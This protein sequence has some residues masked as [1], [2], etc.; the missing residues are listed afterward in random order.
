[1]IE[2]TETMTTRDGVELVATL[3]RPEGDA[4]RPVLLS[5]TP[6]GRA[7]PSAGHHLDV[8]RLVA[9]GYAV[10]LQDVRGTGSSQGEFRFLR[11]EAADGHDAVRWAATRPW[12]DGNVG[13][14][15]DSY[16]A[17]TQLL[18][19]Q[20]R[21]EGL[22]AIAPHVSPLGLY[23][24]V[25]QPGGVANL[26]VFLTVSV[27]VLAVRELD[28]RIAAGLATARDKEA[29]LAAI[30]MPDRIAETL[31][32]LSERLP[33]SDQPLLAEL[34][35]CYATCVDAAD[36]ADP[37]WREAVVD[38][39]AIEVPALVSTGWY[40]CFSAGSI[41]HYLRLRG[42]RRLIVGPWSHISHDR[43]ICGRDYG[44]R[45][46]QDAVDWTGI[47][48]D[49]F[50]HWLRGAPARDTTP[51]KIFV[52]GA[53]EWRDEESWPLT[54]A[55]PVP[56][57]LGA[58]GTLT[59]EPAVHG[60]NAG[61]GAFTADPADPVPTVGG[62]VMTFDAFGPLDQRPL[63]GR[64]DVLRHRT[65]PLSAAVEV[66]GHVELVALVS[67]TAPS[68]DVTAKLIDVHP[69]GRAELLI[70]G[71]ARVT[72]LTP[73]EPAAVRVPLGW[74]SN[75]FRPGHRIR[76]DVAGSNFPRFARN[77]DKGT[78]TLHAPS[79]VVLP[80]IE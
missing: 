18:A 11:G 2:T 76:I 77:P 74:T 25:H 12:S 27:V 4:P 24:C 79:Y 60:Q 28:R 64:D 78:T 54:R 56:Y 66:S 67:A 14:Y 42:P 19:A 52:M 36:P 61:G 43:D 65:E 69:D 48:L 68:A 16:L 33:P 58:G 32:E 40:D 29:Y 55:R 59:R 47:H 45:A 34:V 22:R 1:M 57:H 37:L 62:A 7:V 17:I 13:M 5:R 80:T 50:G 41:E 75:L 23:E 20:E 15:G 6:Y 21:P 73:G 53:D 30:G 38:H 35:P 26:N 3:W 9:A 10:C 44:D 71:V 31:Q 63:D 72:G 51:V 49:W 46:S 70:D 39:A 8:E